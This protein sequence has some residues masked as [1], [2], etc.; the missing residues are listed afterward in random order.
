MVKTKL[1][2]CWRSMRTRCSYPRTNGYNNYGGRGIKV[3]EEWKEL[4][5]FYKWCCE[6]GYKEGLE[7]D[8][9]D[10]N[11]N[12]EPSNCCWKTIKEQCNNK[13]N[14]NVVT[15]NNES[16]TI[17]EWSE[18]TGIDYN[19]LWARINKYNWSIE[20]ALTNNKRGV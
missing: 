1:W 17:M 2:R 11:G 6:S 14:N 16:H 4:E 15:F 19:V 10:V 18:K 20:K 13:R 12:Y 5:N 3:C 7:L 9:I 8:R